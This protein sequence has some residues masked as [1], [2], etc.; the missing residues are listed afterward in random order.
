MYLMIHFLCIELKKILV[1]EKFCKFNN[2][3]FSIATPT[4]KKL[5]DGLPVTHF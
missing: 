2:Y 4:T 3:F 1:S 5:D